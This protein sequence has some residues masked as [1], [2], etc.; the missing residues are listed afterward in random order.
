M[1]V[2]KNT[3][4]HIVKSLENLAIKGSIPYFGGCSEK[5]STIKAIKRTTLKTF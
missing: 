4:L 3:I 2:T 1:I 5:F